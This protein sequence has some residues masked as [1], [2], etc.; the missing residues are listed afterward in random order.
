MRVLYWTIN[1]VDLAR[2]LFRRGADGIIT[3]FP[4]RMQELA[5]A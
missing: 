5:S 1:D 4:A 2:E 3:D